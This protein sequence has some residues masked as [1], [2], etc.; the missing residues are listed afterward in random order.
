M[1]GPEAQT[2]FTGLEADGQRF[3][4]LLDD[5]GELL[6]FYRQSTG[7]PAMANGSSL[8]PKFTRVP[9]VSGVYWF[10]DVFV[11][12]HKPVLVQ[13]DCDECPQCNRATRVRWRGF[14]DILWNELDTGKRETLWCGP[15]KSPW[16]K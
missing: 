14:G 2:T 4:D 8:A 5:L 10:W 13:V 6:E 7:V 16:G 11:V 3:R 15:L 12:A 1:S 9:Q